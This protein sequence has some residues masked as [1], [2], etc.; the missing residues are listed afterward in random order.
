MTSFGA[1]AAANSIVIGDFNRDG[2]QDLAIVNDSSNTVSILLG[3]GAG[4]FANPTSFSIGPN[5]RTLA[6]GDFNGD[7][8][9]DLAV[10]NYGS[11]CMSS[12]ST[13]LGDGLGNF[14]GTTNNIVNPI[15]FLI[16]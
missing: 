1:S 13:L 12:V 2:K 9:Q 4:H 15:L 14:V 11:S 16:P 3:D 8:K 6:V 7:G 10:A 5:P